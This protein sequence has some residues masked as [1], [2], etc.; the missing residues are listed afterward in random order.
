MC[1]TTQ[2]VWKTIDLD[3][4]VALTS[5][6][7]WKCLWQGQI[8]FLEGPCTCMDL[9]C[10]KGTHE[11]V[12][13]DFKTLGWRKWLLKKNQLTTPTSISLF[14]FKASAK[15]QSTPA[16][17]LYFHT[18]SS[19]CSNPGSSHIAST[20]WYRVSTCWLIFCF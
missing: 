5:E 2:K 3:N 12:S 19:W 1:R 4:F 14:F 8:C 15:H 6:F 13:P 9:P 16:S 10:S 7:R 11:K 17:G 18:R 20:H